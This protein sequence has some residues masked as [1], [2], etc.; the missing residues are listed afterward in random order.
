MFKKP[1]TNRKLRGCTTR[2]FNDNWNDFSRR[3]R[4]KLN[5][6]RLLKTRSAEGLRKSRGRKVRKDF[7]PVVDDCEDLNMHFPQD[8][9]QF[10][11]DPSVA[12]M[13]RWRRGNVRKRCLDDVWIETPQVGGSN[14][15][16]SPCIQSHDLPPTDIPS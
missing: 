10:L 14:A 8:A 6:S 16:I 5:K 13:L 4:Q 1:H 15:P 12:V 3:G 2:C 9:C 11:A 7:F